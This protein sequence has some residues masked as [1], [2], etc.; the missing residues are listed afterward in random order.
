MRNSYIIGP[1]SGVIYNNCV[2]SIECVS[3]GGDT[4]LVRNSRVNFASSE[5]SS[6]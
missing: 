5:R 6:I 3:E 4:I 2:R 1:V